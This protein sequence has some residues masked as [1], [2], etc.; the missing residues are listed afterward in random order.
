MN[1]LK[2]QEE[3]T[4]AANEASNKENIDEE[5]DNLIE[6]IRK[7]I[8]KP[9]CVWPELIRLILKSQKRFDFYPL[10]ERIS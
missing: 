4:K 10:D 3:K 5:E 8:D 7:L 6:E 2:H 1:E 9:D